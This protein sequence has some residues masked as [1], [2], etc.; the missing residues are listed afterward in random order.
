[1]H[2]HNKSIQVRRFTYVPKTWEYEFIVMRSNSCQDAL[3]LTPQLPDRELLFARKFFE[4]PAQMCSPILRSYASACTQTSQDHASLR[5][6]QQKLQD[7][8]LR[9]SLHPCFA[10]L[11]SLLSLIWMWCLQCLFSVE[12]WGP[13]RSPVS[14]ESIGLRTLSR[15]Y[16]S[17][18]T[19]LP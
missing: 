15:H 5:A 13:A 1:M 9:F 12:S 3:R 17:A 8:S 11:I 19:A 14:P 4:P 6:Y 2:A 16:G 7:P 18:R 10:S